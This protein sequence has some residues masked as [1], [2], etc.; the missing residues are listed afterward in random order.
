[1]TFYSLNT[2]KVRKRVQIAIAKL[3]TNHFSSKTRKQMLHYFMAAMLILLATNL[4][5]P[6]YK[7]YKFMSDLLANNSSAK[8]SQT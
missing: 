3:I 7:R 4:T 1:M 5:F 8:I 2:R 6:C